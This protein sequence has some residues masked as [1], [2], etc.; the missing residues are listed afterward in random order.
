MKRKLDIRLYVLSLL[1]AMVALIPACK[2]SN[3]SG[4]APIISAVRNYAVSPNDTV[5]HSALAKNQY[6]VITGQNLQNAT[7]ISFDGVPASFN[8]AL[9]A[10]NSAVVQIP[11]IVFTQIDTTKLF[12]VTYKTTAG[13]TTFSF[14]LG[15][16][17]PVI[18]TIS[19]VFA[20]PGKDSLFLYG[21]NLGPI[22]S[23]SYGGVTISHPNFRVSVAG[24]SVFFKMPVGQTNKLIILATP[25]GTARDTINATPVISSISNENANPGDS[26]WVYGNYLNGIT[27]FSFAGVQIGSY[28][29]TTFPNTT[30]TIVGFVMPSNAQPAP[31]IVTTPFGTGKT[32]F[33]VQ[34][35][36]TGSILSLDYGTGNYGWQYWG[37]ANVTSG[38]SD[39]PGNSQSYAILNNGPLS[40]GEG[41]NYSS[42][43]IRIQNETWVPSAHIGDPP[44]NWAVKFEVSIPKPWNGTTIAISTDANNSSYIYR[45]EPWQITPTKRAAITTGGWRT[46][47]IPL[48]WFRAND[49]TL[50]YGEG[51]P[52]ANIADLTGAAGNNPQSFFI[53]H[54]YGSATSATG[55]YGAFGNIRVVKIK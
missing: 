6:V 52:L 47:T 17:P 34:D 20:I 10:S 23:F 11:N 37:G 38:N 39:F 31:V 27:S 53:D 24:D 42:Y 51:L 16:P 55:F 54:N 13:T 12:T 21:S 45:W 30:A 19:N 22:K 28:T 26:V 25:F 33:N 29:V 4:A 32:V 49:P 3:D 48:S 36:A 2:K 35:R 18:A 15:A 14:K 40:S 41:N 50:G 9:L 7:S 44:S 1:F 8:S 43:A 5:L 46:V